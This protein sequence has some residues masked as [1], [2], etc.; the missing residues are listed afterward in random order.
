MPD[1]LFRSLAFSPMRPHDRL[2][3]LIRLDEFS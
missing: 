1:N 3:S 2:Y